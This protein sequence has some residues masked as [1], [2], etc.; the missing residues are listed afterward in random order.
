MSDTTLYLTAGQ[1]RLRYGGRSDMWLHR[2]LHRPDSG[3]PRP[4]RL[5]GR[6]Y[7]LLADLESYERAR[8]VAAAP[9][10]AATAGEA[11]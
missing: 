9:D 6:R 7:W 2:N 3:F 8:M 10:E 11:A 5:N 1:V 4:L